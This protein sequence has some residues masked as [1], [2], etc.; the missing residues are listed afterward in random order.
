[1]NK[2]MMCPGRIGREVGYS[3]TFNP[4]YGVLKISESGALEWKFVE[5][6]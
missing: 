6:E 5:V 2:W 4:I 1:M 3:G